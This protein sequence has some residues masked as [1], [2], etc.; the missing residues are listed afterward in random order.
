MKIVGAATLSLLN[1]NLNSDVELMLARLYTLTL[2]NGTVYRWTDYETDLTPALTTPVNSAFSAGSGSIVAGTYWYRLTALFGPAIESTGSTQTSITLGGTGGVNVNWAAVSGATGYSIYGRTNGG[3]GYL[4][5]VGPNT[6]TWLDNGSAAV[7][8]VPPASNPTF[9][10]SGPAIVCGKSRQ[11]RGVELC[12]AEVHLF[13]GGSSFTLG[14]VSLSRAA[15][16]GA[17]DNAK[18]EITKLF[19]AFPGDTSKQPLCWF[20]GL[21]SEATPKSSGVQLSLKGTTELLANLQWPKRLLMPQCPY[22]LYDANC[23]LAK[24]PVVVSVQSG[25]TT[26]TVTVAG[27]SHGTYTL[28]TITF[29][30]GE[31]R[32]IS[33]M[34]NSGANDVLT[35]SMPLNTAP[36]A[37]TN[38]ASVLLGCNKSLTTL[39]TNS[40]NCTTFGN[41]GNFGGFPFVPRPESIR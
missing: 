26:S 3:E 29:A 28:G 7:G 18:F 41:T 4:A 11:V 21:V 17:F 6:L 40:G 1:L 36:S 13:G 34:A 5:T 23:G 27:L 37:G 38:N 10:S 31:V 14:G 16:Q 25:A 12:E 19:M 2:V 8:A 39:G 20:S 24:S 22:S 35:L 15:L 33:S 30:D 9:S 32:Q